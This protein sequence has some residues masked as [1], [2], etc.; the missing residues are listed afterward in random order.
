[1]PLLKGKPGGDWLGAG[2]RGSWVRSLFYL[3]HL[4]P[5]GC[6]VTRLCVLVGSKDRLALVLFGWGLLFLWSM[7]G[8][9]RPAGQQMGHFCAHR[10]S[11]HVLGAFPDSPSSVPPAPTGCPQCPGPASSAHTPSTPQRLLLPS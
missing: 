11:C 10:G 6:R 1:M 4:M 5:K 2:G 3:S 7:A 9:E 8:R